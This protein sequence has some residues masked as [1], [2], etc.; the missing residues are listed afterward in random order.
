[1]LYFDGEVFSTELF[2]SELTKISNPLTL[3]IARTLFERLMVSP[4]SI[5]VI[6]SIPI[7]AL[8]KSHIAILFSGRH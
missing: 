5:A 3:E 8:S 1:M 6:R 4:L 2:E 7:H